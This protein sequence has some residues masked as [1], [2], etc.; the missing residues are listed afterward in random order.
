MEYKT[1]LLEREGN[2]G[3]LILNRPE[4]LNAMTYEMAWEFRHAID[5]I[6]S[7]PD[8]RVLVITGAGKGFC[9]GF[10][11]G[12][13]VPKGLQGDDRRSTALKFYKSFL[14]IQDLEIPTIAMLNGHAVGAGIAF[15]LACDIRIASEN[16]RFGFTFIRIALHPGM[17]TTYLLPRIVGTAKALELLW[18]GEMITATQAAEIGLVDRVVPLNELRSTTMEIANRLAKGPSIPMRMIKKAVYSGLNS[19]METILQFEAMAQDICMGTEDFK[20]GISAFKE[21]REPVFKGR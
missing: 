4:N 9:S 7:S 17:G 6:S 15:P 5:E 16:A 10:D 3:I 19:D 20:E 18:T 8:I 21:K 1:I 2:V 14:S 12:G 11:I 13:F